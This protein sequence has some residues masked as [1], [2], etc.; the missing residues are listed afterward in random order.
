[1]EKKAPKFFKPVDFPSWY[2]RLSSNFRHYFKQ[3]LFVD[4]IFYC[5]GGESIGAHRL[6]LWQ[7]SNLFR[8][9]TS[10]T[11]E[12]FYNEDNVVHISVPEVTKDN[13]SDFIEAIYLGAVPTNYETFYNFQVRF[14]SA[15]LLHP[16]ILP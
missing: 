11:E 2:K 4:V 12:Y 10:K 16:S 6:M 13:L 1:M 9:L 15:G 7:S 5:Q 8:T 3:Q 14:L